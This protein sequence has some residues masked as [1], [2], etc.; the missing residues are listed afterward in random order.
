MAPQLAAAGMGRSASVPGLLKLGTGLPKIDGH[1][2][3]NTL[4]YRLDSRVDIS[5]PPVPT[6]EAVK[7][8][9]MMRNPTWRHSAAELRPS[10][11]T[12]E[13][14][15]P[16]NMRHPKSSPPWLKHDRQVLRFYGFFQ[17]TVTER[18]DENSRYRQLTM[19]YYMEDG[20]FM[21]IEPKVENSGI[22]QGSFLKR[23]RVPRHDGN[24]FIGPDD[25][26]CGEEITIYKKVCHITGCDRFTRWFYEENGI[27]VGEDEPVVDDMWQRSYK[28]SKTA[29]KGGI[30]PSRAAIGEKTLTKY[31]VGGPPQ[32]KKM[33][34]FLLNDRKV[35]RFKAYWDD[36]TL[37]GQRF[38]FTI[39]YYLANNTVEINEAHCK[40]SGRDNYPVFYKRAPL[41]KQNMQTAVPSM[42][43][44]DPV[45]YLPE[46]LIIGQVIYVW[47]RKVV[48]YDC[49]DFTRQFYHD[50]MGVDQAESRLDVSERPIQHLRLHPP[51]HT[52]GIGTEEDSLNNCKTI[53][54]K[55]PK[56]DLMKLLTLAGEVLR[57]EAKMVNGE[58]EDETRRVII[59][60][61]PADE[62]CAVFE[63][64][65]RNSGHMG[66][67]FQE[68]GRKRNPDTGSWFGLGDFYVG[69]TVTIAAQPFHIVRAD[70]H[71]LQYLEGRPRE[72]PYADPGACVHRLAPIADEMEMQNDSG[73]DP[74]RLKE[75]AADAGLH[76]IDHEIITL[77][78]NFSVDTEEGVP[79]ISGPRV[80]EAIR[81]S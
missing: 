64:S 63:L 49:D 60:Y 5:G 66:G 47:R 12:E 67:K 28:F 8:V 20:T 71:C 70:E 24:G 55:P 15:V 61:Y 32:D 42:L 27:D 39:H 23:H 44:P 72:F 76:L 75:L 74:D 36:H 45:P 3:T 19:H 14:V 78:R 29:E 40:N 69:A 68:K 56:Q 31:Q 13:E 52:S 54:P 2:K 81:G 58:P 11:P 35:L 10:T 80:V 57:F 59:A 43:M 79:L 30:P 9:D 51:P 37:Y 50:Y 18:S 53:Q 16:R 4:A 73:I 7:T 46:D 25:F 21:I 1:K 77:L 38:Y 26:R 6:D 41:Y 65:S 62:T 22:P 33:I 17:E 48:L 34:Q